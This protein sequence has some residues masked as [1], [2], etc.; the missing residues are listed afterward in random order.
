VGSDFETSEGGVMYKRKTKQ[1]NVVEVNVLVGQQLVKVKSGYDYLSEGFRTIAI[2]MRDMLI[3][4]NRL[5][6]LLAKH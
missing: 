5:S 2:E 4:L 3:D 1:G 6:K